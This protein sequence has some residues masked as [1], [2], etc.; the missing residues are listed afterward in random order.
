MLFPV[1]CA[2]VLFPVVCVVSEVPPPLV[3]PAPF[4]VLFPDVVP[5]VPLAVPVVPADVPVLLF[6]GVT[7]C[8]FPLGFNP[9][10]PPPCV[11]P[12]VFP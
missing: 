1:V 6:T 9:L 8:V 10:S 2:V 12:P 5:V 4:C 7:A 3:F 11:T